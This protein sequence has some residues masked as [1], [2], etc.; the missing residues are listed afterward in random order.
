MPVRSTTRT[1]ARPAPGAFLDGDNIVARTLAYIGEIAM[2]FGQVLLF[3]RKPGQAVEQMAVIG[4][5]SLPIALVTI[6]F[7]GMVLVLYTAGEMK[8][9]GLGPFVGGL[10][11][12]IM[13]RE[14]APVL[15][16]VVVAARAGSAIAAEI[17]SM[18]VTEQ[19]DALRALAAS[20][21]QHLVVPRFIACV[22][23]LP[24]VAL[25]GF[26]AGAA[27]GY[28]VALPEGIS[29]AS[30]L[31]S[32]RQFMTFSDVYI[33]IS[34]TAVFGAII[35]L[36]ACHQGLNARGGAT[37]VGQATTRSVVLCIVFIFVADFLMT[38]LL[39]GTLQ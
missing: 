12:L 17:G 23:M 14:L 32:M 34:K 13:S 21:I 27:G 15:A 6:S 1:A 20:P 7:A 37:G 33:G 26:L 35:A 5:N 38:R 9:R 2:M 3:L 19:I 18:K 11:G 31:D 4:V 36:V 8:Q 16:G 10:V 25:F 30:Y 24:V 28:I 29:R 22:V 39:V